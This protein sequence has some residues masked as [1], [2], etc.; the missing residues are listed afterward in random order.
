[1]ASW[2]DLTMNSSR[3]A[4]ARHRSRRGPSGGRGSG[5]STRPA[6]A[7]GAPSQGSRLRQ[8]PSSKPAGGANGA[9][10]VLAAPAAAGRANSRPVAGV[11]D[12]GRFRRSRAADLAV[13][14]VAERAGHQE[15]RA[16]QGTS[17]GQSPDVS[18]ALVVCMN[19]V[20]SRSLPDATRAGSR[21]LQRSA[22]RNFERRLLVR[23]AEGL[24][25]R[26][27]TVACAAISSH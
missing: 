7:A 22:K 1:M 19:P 10:H 12:G 4:P 15:T 16:W 5:R 21:A 3:R 26:A 20:Q 9:V 13:D 23:T 8:R 24:A 27:R 6:G 25:G 2:P 11:V 14:D 17:P 18:G